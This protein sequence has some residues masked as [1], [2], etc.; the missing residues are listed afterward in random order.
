MHP[1][2]LILPDW[3]SRDYHVLATACSWMG[4]DVLWIDRFSLDGLPPDCPID[5]TALHGGTTFCRQVAAALGGRVIEPADDLLPG[6]P[7]RFRKRHVELTT[8]AKARSRTDLRFVK[9]VNDKFF[10]AGVYEWPDDIPQ[11]DKGDE[12][13]VLVAEPVRWLVEYRLFVLDGVVKT[14]SPYRW[15]E[16]DRPDASTQAEAL[17]FGAL[18]LDEA[19]ELLPRAVVVDVGI[20]DGAGWAVVEANTAVM[21]GI[22]DCEPEA[23]LE[24]SAA[25]IERSE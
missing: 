20:I 8:L 5:G 4:I 16:D 9:P 25:G 11:T 18:V 14:L 17:A 2:R 13:A 12:I 3:T 21:S 15:A 1:N 7:E 10:A 23:V 19:G 24:V 22:Y 6:L